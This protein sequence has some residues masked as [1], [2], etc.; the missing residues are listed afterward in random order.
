MPTSV[1]AYLELARLSNGPT[2]LSNVLVGAAIAVY[3]ND[4]GFADLPWATITIV[5]VAMLLYYVGGMALN[6]VIDAEID[7]SERPERPIPSGRVTRRGAWTLIAFAFALGIGLLAT[8]G[9]AASAVGAVLLITIIA[10]NLLHKRFAGSALLMG[11]CRGLVYV[12]AAAAIDWHATVRVAFWPTLALS[13]YVFL[14]TVIARGEATN[15]IGASRRLSMAMVIVAISPSLFILPSGTRA[16]SAVIVAGIALITWLVLL[17]RHLLVTPPR[18]KP[19]ILGWLAGICLLDAFYL[20]L[21]EQPA[22]AAIAGLCF[23]M[24]IGA[25]R[26]VSGT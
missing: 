21:L 1:R 17:Q 2:V 11:L 16:V 23:L 4:T 15:R 25:H 19:A 10:Y 20:A 22:L 13:V 24:T 12:T 8:C 3:A 5:M 26:A 9:F 14:V 18:M 7:L 6:D